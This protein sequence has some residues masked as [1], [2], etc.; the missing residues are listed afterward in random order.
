MTMLAIIGEVKNMLDNKVDHY[1][2]YEGIPPTYKKNVVRSFVFI[3]QKL[4]PMVTW[5]SSK[6][7]WW[8][9]AANKIIYMT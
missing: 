6:Q 2:K 3:K 9:M 4:F 1:I 5:I 7:D 8:P